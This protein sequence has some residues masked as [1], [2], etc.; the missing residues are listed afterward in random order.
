MP[1]SPPSIVA[2][3]SACSIQVHLQGQLTG[4]TVHIYASPTNIFDEVFSGT[5]SW[6][7]EVFTLTRRLK[8]GETVYATQSVPGDGP[9]SF[10]LTETVEPEPDLSEVGPIAMDSHLHVCG[11]CGALGNGL[12]GAEVVVVSTARGELGRADIDPQSGAA[13]VQFVSPLENGEVLK[14]QQSI[15]GHKGPVTALPALDFPANTRRVL[16]APTIKGPLRACECAVLV[17]N[18][19]VGAI[20]TL[21]R[22]GEEYSAACFDFSSIWFRVADP[23]KKDERIKVDQRFPDCELASPFSNEIKVGPPEDAPQP[24]L[25]GP[26]CKGT[27]RIGVGN[28][29][30]GARVR[31]VQTSGD[32]VMG[33][34]IADA[35][36]W[37]EVCDIPLTGPLDA[38]QGKYL[39][40]VQSLC[41]RDSP[42]SDRA[43]IHA[44]HGMLPPPWIVGPVTECG[45]MVRVT[46]IEPGARIEVFMTCAKPPGFRRIAV[47]QVH[48]KVADIA[49]TPALQRGQMAFVRQIA[50]NQ[51][52]DS[53]AVNV[54]ASSDLMPPKVEDCDDHLDVTGVIPGARVEVYRNGAYFKDGRSGSTEVRIPLAAPLAAGDVIKAR[55][56]MCAAMSAFGPELTIRHDVEKRRLQTV[57]VTTKVAPKFPAFPNFTEDGPKFPAFPNFAT[58]RICTLSA[59]SD[60]EGL[61]IQNNCAA[62]GIAGADL[63]IVVD[64]DT[65]DHRLYFFFGDTTAADPDRFKDRWWSNADCMARTSAREA[66]Q[67][68]SNLDF[69]Y[70]I[71]D[72]DEPI[73]RPC[74]V[75]GI[76]QET[77][78]VPTGGFS[79][80]GKLYVFTTTD[81]YNG[82]PITVD[83][84]HDGNFM[85]RSVL[86]AASDWHDD[87]LIVPGHDDIS[88]HTR[89]ASGGFKFINIAPW[90]IRNDDWKHLP[91]NAVPGGEG[92]IL[93]GSGRYRES[94]T[95]LAYVPLPPGGDPVFSEWRYLSGFAAPSAESG[96]CGTPQWSPKQEDALFLW[97]DSA[98]FPGGRVVPQNKGVVGEL[99]IAFIPQLRLWIALYWDTAT[100]SATHPWGPWS[101]PIKLFDWFRDQHDPNGPVDPADPRPRYIAPGGASYG[102]YIVPRFTEYEPV[103]GNVTFY[104]AMSTWL[105]YAAVLLKTTVRLSCGY[106]PIACPTS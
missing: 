54:R 30:Y 15:C 49:V 73:P 18:V 100:R 106:R 7:D 83:L 96:P 50:C 99:S 26:F 74:D 101:D 92:L 53:R 6:P 89:E 65:G 11:R 69:L 87:F 10:P 48:T 33:L 66:G 60:P 68:G 58:E 61:L 59:P 67:F 28:L 102:P 40:A 8:A 52:V 42:Q 24:K 72:D 3:L 27:T 82:T 25:L 29:C 43:E 4:A 32:F 2:P 47:R 64:H 98:F 93:M 95:C 17:E 80:A 55:Q 34:P 103:T 35:E 88:N 41:D 31:I 51:T 13:R 75:L 105:P 57:P 12:P 85:G 5:A 78:E 37:D 39:I 76:T 70:D 71:D 86:A 16:A 62:A 46:G 19:A 9:G 56:L 91:S 104:Y 22:E 21:Y 63:G 77:F 79:H 36:A 81:H 14:A 94:Q 45:R 38:A 84:M 1:L 97:N 90:K 23:L 44:L 20:V